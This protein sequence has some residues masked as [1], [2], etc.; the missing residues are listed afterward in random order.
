MKEIPYRFELFPIARQAHATARC[1]SFFLFSPARPAEDIDIH[2]LH[3]LSL[4]EEVV[5][6][7]SPKSACHRI[8]HSFSLHAKVEFSFFS[9]FS[10][11]SR[12]KLSLVVV[13]FFFL[14]FSS[15]TDWPAG[16]ASF[17]PSPPLVALIH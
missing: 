4:G 10:L 12:G 9:F 2:S 3:F 15:G 17:F 16:A 8:G 1:L 5:I 11:L 13:P 6:R 7:L 14:F